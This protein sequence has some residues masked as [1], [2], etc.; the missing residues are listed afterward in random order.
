ME[1]AGTTSVKLWRNAAE[2]SGGIEKQVRIDKPLSRRET[3][4]L[5][6]SNEINSTCSTLNSIVCD[7][8]GVLCKMIFT[9]V[10]RL[11]PCANLQVALELC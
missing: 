7:S 9:S 6:D 8:H 5:V 11:S 3:V 2:L 10:V 4:N 1:H